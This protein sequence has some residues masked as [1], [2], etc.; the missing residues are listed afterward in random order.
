MNTRIECKHAACAQ[1][2]ISRVITRER[3]S[4][5]ADLKKTGVKYFTHLPRRPPHNSIESQEPEILQKIEDQVG[6]EGKIF[7]STKKRER[8]FYQS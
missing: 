8:F 2:Y 3:K 5:K 1:S 7:Y 4:E 6:E